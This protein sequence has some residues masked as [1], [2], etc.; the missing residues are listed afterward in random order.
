MRMVLT[1][2]LPNFKAAFPIIKEQRIRNYFQ[3]RYILKGRN[4]C[5]LDFNSFHY[6]IQNL[7]D[8]LES[9]VQE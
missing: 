4:I 7:Q 3:P 5:Y 8:A 1:M 6:S 9:N 2:S